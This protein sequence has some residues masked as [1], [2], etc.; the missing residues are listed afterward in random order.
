MSKLS[1]WGRWLW[2]EA[3]LTA[4]PTLQR[5]VLS[6]LHEAKEIGRLV[7]RPS[8]TLQQWQG[9]GRGGPLTVDYVGLGYARPFIKHLLFLEEPPT[10]EIGRIPFWSLGEQVASLGGDITIVEA[11]KHLIRG[12]S[13]P[14]AISLPF[15]LHHV[16]DLQRDWEE[17]WRTFGNSARKQDVRLVRKYGYE[18]ELSR[19]RDDL[20]MFYHTMYVPTTIERHGRLASLMSI[21]GLY[22]RFRHGVLILAKRDGQFVSG[23]LCPVQHKTVYLSV[24]GVLN[25]DRQLSREGAVAGIYYFLIRW[26]H[27]AGYHAVNLG[28]CWPFLGD[29]IFQFKRKWGASVLIPPREHKLIWMRVRRDT[30]AVNQFITENPCVVVGDKGQLL[31]LIV[32][33]SDDITP[34]VEA[35]C[36]KRYATPGLSDLV[37]C[38]VTELLQ[39][40]G[41]KDGTGS[42]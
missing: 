24:T 18:Y 42:D 5:T 21:E 35:E 31:G 8:M 9:Q 38:S 14:G 23:G 7:I 4:S 12:F 28:A 34:E 33:D 39:R 30:P 26:A 41:R 25:A 17:L 1:E 19:N 40:S 16:V 36:R 11:S 29:G 20:E 27:E 15:R 10:R 32:T 37:I 3:E 22:Q 6:R 2:V 13:H